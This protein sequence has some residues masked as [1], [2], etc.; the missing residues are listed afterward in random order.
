MNM[1]LKKNSSQCMPRQIIRG[2]AS[3]R[4]HIFWLFFAIFTGIALSG[5]AQADSLNLVTEDYPPYNFL[6]P[7][8]NEVRGIVAD[9]VREIMRRTGKDFS[10]K[11]YP[12]QRALQ[13][14]RTEANTCVFATARL[15]ERE[16]ELK[17]IGPVIKNHWV[18]L[19][20]ADDTRKPKSLD[21]I[22]GAVIG[23]YRGTSMVGFLTEK[24]FQVD[25]APS[26][27]E[28]PRKLLAGRFDFW[29]ASEANSLALIKAQGYEGQ[30]VPL[31]S[32]RDTELFLACNLSVDD[33]QIAR[34]NLA[35]KQMEQDGSMQRIERK[36]H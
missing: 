3:T 25:L 6:A 21:D 1:P 12:W 29:A 15:P 11:I 36:Y 28:N 18:M 4:C 13:M 5:T 27:T 14:A 8:G 17:W 16:A 20:R 26:H 9:K 10:I 34:M 22:K 24:G 23:S 32:F 30:I 31:F 33:K 35:V 7:D 2:R 19:A